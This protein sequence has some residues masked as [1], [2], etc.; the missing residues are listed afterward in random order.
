MGVERSDAASAPASDEAL[1]VLV[2]APDLAVADR[3][4]ADLVQRRIAACVNLVEGVTSVYRWEGQ[5]QR[6][7]EV[8]MV[9]KT[10]RARL[11]ELEAFLGAEH[12]YEVPECVALAPAHVAGPYL[13]WLRDATRP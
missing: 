6:A 9:V 3:L 7:A 13:G 12:P 4:A 2:T 8:L 1:V 10:V 5:V 11:R